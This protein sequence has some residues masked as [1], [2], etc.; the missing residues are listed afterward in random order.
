MP[1]AAAASFLPQL[2]TISAAAGRCKPSTQ[3]CCPFIRALILTNSCPP[4]SSSAHQMLM[5][6]PPAARALALAAAKYPSP[7]GRQL[8]PT[9]AGCGGRPPGTACPSPSKQSSGPACAQH[10]LSAAAAAILGE[11]E[12]RPR[13]HSGP[14]RAAA[15]RLCSAL[16]TRGPARPN[17][18]AV[19][20]VEEHVAGKSGSA[21]SPAAA[22]CLGVR[23]A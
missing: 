20:G 16:L 13:A 15:P 8:L 10:G 11:G 14:L 1:P 5:A 17:R 4:G 18:P 9:T 21:S 2:A 6:W 23:C 12:T 19:S 3:H 22:R 7:A